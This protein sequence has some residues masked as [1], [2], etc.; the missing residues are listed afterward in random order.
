MQSINKQY[1]IE[2]TFGFGTG[3]LSF[4]SHRY[5]DSSINTMNNFEPTILG[6]L[7]FAM[8]VAEIN[9]VLQV[10]LLVMTIVYTGY[11]ILE[12]IDKRK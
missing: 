3:H 10:V 2:T 7:V 4:D 8:S 1:N 6:V 5:T 9:D 11:K 12:L